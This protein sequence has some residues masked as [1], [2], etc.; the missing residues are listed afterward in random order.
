MVTKQFT[1]DAK[2][3]NRLRIDLSDEA[4]CKENTMAFRVLGWKGHFEMGK[5][6]QLKGRGIC[7]QLV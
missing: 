2:M 5:S 6:S 7:Q 1:S 3:K 4:Y